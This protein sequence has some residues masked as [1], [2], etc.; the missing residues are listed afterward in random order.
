[1]HKALTINVVNVSIGERT[2]RE[3]ACKFLE[4][5]VVI[6][7]SVVLFASMATGSDIK[8]KAVLCIAGLFFGASVLALKEEFEK[9]YA[10]R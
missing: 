1:M 8:E 9:R 7:I 2:G 6:A 4:I 5:L 10:R 3:H